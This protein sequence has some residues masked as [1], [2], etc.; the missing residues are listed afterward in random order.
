MLIHLNLVHNDKEIFRNYENADFNYF[1][2]VGQEEEK[3]ENIKQEPS[4]EKEDSKEE[5][6]K[7]EEKEQLKTVDYIFVVGFDHK[8][9]SVIEFFHPEPDESI[10]D[11]NVKKALSFIGLPDGSHITE[12]DYSFFIVPDA[13]GNLYYGVSWFRQIKSSEIEVKDVKVSRSFIQKSVWVLSR[14]PIF[15]TLMVKLLPTTHAFFNQKNFTDIK[16]LEEFYGGANHM[17][18]KIKYGDFYT[19][20]DLKR[21]VIYMKHNIL[22]IMKLILL[23]GKVVVYSSKASKAWTFVLTLISLLPGGVNFN[24]GK[25]DKIRKVMQHYKAYGLPLKVFNSRC[26]FLPLSTLNDLD[27]LGKCKGFV[28]GCTNKLLAQYPSI[29]LD[30]VI[31]LDDC[32]TEFRPTELWKLAKAHSSTERHFINSLVKDLKQI[33]TEMDPN[34]MYCWDSTNQDC[35]PEIESLDHADL[36]AKNAFSSYFKQLLCR[37]AYAEMWAKNQENPI[38]KPITSGNDFEEFKVSKNNLMGVEK[39]SEANEFWVFR[40]TEDDL[41]DVDNVSIKTNDKTIDEVK[42][43]KGSSEIEQSKDLNTMSD[44][45]QTI[46]LLKEY[47]IKFIKEWTRTYNFH[48][49]KLEHHNRCAYLDSGTNSV[50]FYKEKV[51]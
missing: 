22:T 21:L 16:I 47:N 20:L 43:Q 50:E 3:H 2:D 48:K 19:G 34:D 9:G 36:R 51:T 5:E 27:L 45:S 39:S 8:I 31:N 33:A 28:V 29:K 1:C 42:E 12:S 23:E 38:A 41:E 6:E 26:V 15:G 35:M 44:Y 13:H 17:S 4:E 32:T 7:E 18:I 49:W 40:I 30:W 11:D 24:F 25:E 37:M 46:D 14:I 10:I